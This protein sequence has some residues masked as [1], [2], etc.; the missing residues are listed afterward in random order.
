[1]IPWYYR[2]I[3]Y[4]NKEKVIYI[5]AYINTTKIHIMNECMTYYIKN[6]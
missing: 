3:I 4:A 6:Y 5:T 1:M 2:D